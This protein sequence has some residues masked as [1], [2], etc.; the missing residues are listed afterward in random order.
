MAIRMVEDAEEQGL[1]KPGF[2][3]I[4]PTSGNTGIGLAMACAVKGYDCIIVMPEKM[5]DEKEA[6]LKVLGARIVRVPNLLHHDDPNGF[7]GR[8]RRL[9]KEIPNSIILGY[10]QN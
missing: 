8:A 1:L 4:E 2:T 6:T 5:S 7:L 9:N 3:V 10:I